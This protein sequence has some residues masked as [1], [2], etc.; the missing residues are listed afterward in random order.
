MENIKKIYLKNLKK[1]KY[2]L[3]LLLNQTNFGSTLHDDVTI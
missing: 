1:K 3:F 2:I